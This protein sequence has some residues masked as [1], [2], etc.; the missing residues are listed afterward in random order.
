M[1]KSFAAEG[2]VLQAGIAIV[3]A[4][5]GIEGVDEFYER[6]FAVGPLQL[7]ALN[8]GSDFQVEVSLSN[9]EP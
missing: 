8:D 5:A 7:V 9:E 2:N 4:S 6:H 3:E 1:K